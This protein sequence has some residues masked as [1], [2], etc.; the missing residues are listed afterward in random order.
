MSDLNPTK[1]KPFVIDIEPGRYS[2]CQ[3]GLS[4]KLPY[5]DGAHKGSGISPIRVEFTEK[6]RV[7][8]C[9]CHRSNAKPYCDGSHKKITATTQVQ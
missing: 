7:A 5:C 4:K 2:W 6:K 9:G 8:W 1:K 3:C